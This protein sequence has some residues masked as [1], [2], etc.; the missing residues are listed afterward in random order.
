MNT[1]NLS[2]AGLLVVIALS[3]SPLLAKEQ[4]QVPAYE[5][6]MPLDIAKVIRIE[7]PTSPMCEVV[8]AKMT[9]LNTQGAKKHLSFL[10][11]AEACSKQ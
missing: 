6:G 11:L 10:Q 3:G 5:Y 4:T 8:Q 1:Q 9:Y 2:I 7:A